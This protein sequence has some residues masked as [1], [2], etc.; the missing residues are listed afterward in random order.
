MGIFTL[1]MILVGHFLGH[2]L[3]GGS[4]VCGCTNPGAPFYFIHL[5]L[6]LSPS[7]VGDK[8]LRILQRDEMK[9]AFDCKSIRLKSLLR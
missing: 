5:T 7:Q 4:L 3:Q 9:V 2:A 1:I 6:P 8:I